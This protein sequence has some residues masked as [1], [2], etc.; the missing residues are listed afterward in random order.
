MSRIK[1]ELIKILLLLFDFSISN[2]IL[3]F[4]IFIKGEF[5][6]Y[7]L[8]LIKP[9]ESDYFLKIWWIS[10]FL[11][12]I[13]FVKGLYSKRLPLWNEARE[14]VSSVFYVVLISFSIIYLQKLWNFPRSIFVLYFILSIIIIPFLRHWFKL[15]LLKV[16]IYK[17]NM[18][19]VG[20]GTLAK[21]AVNSILKQKEFGMNVVGFVDDLKDEDVIVGNYTFKILGKIEDLEG[22]LNKFNFDTVMMA[23][24]SSDF[25]KVANLVSRIR[26]LVRRLYIVPELKYVAASN[27]QIYTLFDKQLFLL[28][29]NNNLQYLKNRLVKRIFDIMLSILLLPILLPLIFIFG[30][31]IKFDSK[32][33]VFFTQDRLGENGKIFKCVKF[34]TMFIDADKILDRYLESKPEAYKE[35]VK[36]KKIKGY[37]PRVTRVGRLLRRTSLDELPQI[38]NV[39]VGQMSFVGPRPYLV[40]ESNDMGRFKD[41]IL[42]VKPGITG[43]WQVLGRNN[44]TF[45]RRLEI[46]SWYVLNWSLWIDMVILLKT[47][48]VVLER[49][50]VY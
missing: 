47:V 2:I 6:K 18:I 34:R 45:N 11:V 8:L 23:I 9:N 14:I 27:T 15:F 5:G 49:E 13:F 1:E 43:L 16:G 39:L 7:G 29:V 22:V 41:I 12:L 33:P 31:L 28:K 40:S 3:L 32:G 44:L 37:D 24:P 35:W 42:T 36:Y 19:V 46:D 4:S 38:F 21:A 10:I 30:L 26:L 17:R 20:A 48:K 25:E 50:G